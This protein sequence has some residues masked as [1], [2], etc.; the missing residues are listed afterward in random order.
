MQ[1]GDVGKG[2]FVR[3]KFFLLRSAQSRMQETL[4]ARAE[5]PRCTC[6][7]SFFRVERS[8]LIFI[9]ERPLAESNRGQLAQR[10]TKM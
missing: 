7:Q 10:R 4:L 8:E 1:V 6:E 2:R 3:S 9:S 5:L